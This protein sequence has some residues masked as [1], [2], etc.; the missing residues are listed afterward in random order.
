MLRSIDDASGAGGVPT[1]A[2]VDADE[3]MFNVRDVAGHELRFNKTP[4]Q[5]APDD[6]GVC[7]GQNCSAAVEDISTRVEGPDDPPFEA[8]SD[9]NADGG[10]PGT[11]DVPGGAFGFNWGAFRML[12]YGAG[13]D[14][15]CN[16]TET[17]DFCPTEA[18]NTIAL[19]AIVQGPRGSFANPFTAVWFLY[20]TAEGN[21]D[22]IDDSG[23]ASV[24]DNT[25]EN[26]RTFRFR[27]TWNA[28]NLKVRPAGDPGTV[29]T[30]V[31]VGI[32]ADGVVLISAPV[33]ITVEGDP[34]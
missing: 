13:D 29:Y 9:L 12:G 20:L 25:I 15:V 6:G 16:N 27:G 4:W 10:N 24:I 33:S 14:I 31:A 1:N 17:E 3:I 26:T 28:A 11:A 2:F 19:E 30:V 34:E 23:A 22:F 21:W 5:I 8:L 18:S 7:P 32:S